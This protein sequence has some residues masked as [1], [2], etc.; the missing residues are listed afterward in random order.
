MRMDMCADM[1]MDMR[2]DIH[3]CFC[4]RLD[5]RVRVAKNTDW[6][7]LIISHW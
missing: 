1:C 4:I 7:V 3:M 5:V 2:L 6:T